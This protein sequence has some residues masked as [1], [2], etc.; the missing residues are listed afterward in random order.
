MT[1]IPVQ[2][3]LEYL[4]EAIIDASDYQ[5]TGIPIEDLYAAY[6]DLIYFVAFRVTRNAVD[7]EDVVQN[8]FL[9]MMRTDKQPDAGRCAVAYFRRTATN[10]A[11]DLIRKRT[12]RRETDLQPWYSVAEHTFVEEHDVRQAL[13]KLAAIDATLC[14]MHYRDGYLYH[15]LAEHFGIP[16]GTVKSRLHRIRGELQN[17]LRAA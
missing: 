6:R 2:M 14:E 12:Q 10:A 5:K 3:P 17:E 9:R 4:H 7:A 16:V 8:V 15:E 13:N 1:N 11:I